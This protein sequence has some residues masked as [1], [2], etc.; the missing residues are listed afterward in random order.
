[1]GTIPFPAR[2]PD[3]SPPVPR[4]LARVLGIEDH[5]PAT[6][7]VPELAEHLNLSLST[8]YQYLRQGVIPARRAGRRW[9]ISRLRIARWL[10][11]VTEQPDPDV[12]AIELWRER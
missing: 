9:I 3:E 6:F 10:D 5:E 7:T 8:T 4:H 2:D 1:M 11:E 12:S